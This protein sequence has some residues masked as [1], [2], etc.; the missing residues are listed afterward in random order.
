MMKAT[1]KELSVFI[2]AVGFILMISYPNFVQAADTGGADHFELMA[3][4]NKDSK[5]GTEIADL[6]IKNISGITAE[7]VI[8]E[9]DLPEIF[10]DNNG[11]K[12]TFKVA[13]L[14]AG[15]SMTYKVAREPKGVGDSTVLPKTDTPKATNSL[16]QTGD[17]TTPIAVI[18][19]LAVFSSGI[20]FGIKNIKGSKNLLA[21]ILLLAGL[22]GAAV[23]TAD[24]SMYHHRDEVNHHAVELAGTAYVFQLSGEGDFEKEVVSPPSTP[25]PP[26]PVPMPT[27]TYT[28]TFES[29]GGTGVDSATVTGNQ[30]V[31]EPTP[32]PTKDDGIVGVSTIG[33]IPEHDFIFKGW[34]IDETL[35]TAFDFSTAITSDMT[36]YAKWGLPITEAGE[37]N[38]LVGMYSNDF[39]GDRGDTVWFANSWWRIL[40]PTYGL[41]IREDSIG[42]GTYH[43]QVDTEYP[44]EDINAAYFNSVD[45]NGYDRSQLKAMID[46]NYD[47]TIKNTPYE[48][49]VIGVTV[50]N[51]TFNDLLNANKISGSWED[52]LNW[53]ATY[54]D[55]YKETAYPATVGGSGDKQQAF[56]LNSSDIFYYG[57]NDYPE[58]PEDRSLILGTFD[59]SPCFWLR[60]AHKH[61]ADASSFE[62][63][64]F[65]S[66]YSAWRTMLDIRPSLLLQLD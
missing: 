42:T 46:S 33:E 61:S 53:S 65:G 13:T 40:N 63:Y 41:V 66:S 44:D 58:H 57:L 39:L 10:H 59:K 11:K 7:N 45:D 62:M 50:K 14:K 17:I 60:S 38:P 43:F 27:P 47:L 19:G 20:F 28:V 31:L 3:T 52:W 15:E 21:L 4:E 37:N 30:S 36:L 35:T 12:V 32:V 8:L 26:P 51:P 54:E 22:G 16:P 9:A 56:A 29:N 24:M 34:Y 23:V 18:V 1:I 5:S 2:L 25:T 49:Y 6:T 55:Y 48:A 64:H